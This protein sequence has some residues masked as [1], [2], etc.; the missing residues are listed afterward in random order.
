MKCPSV[1]ESPEHG[2]VVLNGTFVLLQNILRLQ[3]LGPVCPRGRT[4]SHRL[5]ELGDRDLSGEA[6]CTFQPTTGG[7]EDISN[8][9]IGHIQIVWEAPFCRGQEKHVFTTGQWSRD[10]DSKQTGDEAFSGWPWFC[11]PSVFC[12]DALRGGYGP[13]V[14]R[15]VLIVA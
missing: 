12:F 3:R 10:K 4:V 6:P 14:S 13:V 9:K 11:D 7:T 5:L 2:S 8:N 15:N 1:R